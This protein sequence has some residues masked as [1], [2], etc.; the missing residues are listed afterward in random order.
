MVK[1]FKSLGPDI[2]IAFLLIG[3]SIILMLSFQIDFYKLISSNQEVI[4]KIIYLT[5]VAI[6]ISTAIHFLIPEALPVSK[7]FTNVAANPKIMM[8]TPSSKPTTP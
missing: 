4:L 1:K 8:A 6:A 7:L 3:L 5:G 2:K